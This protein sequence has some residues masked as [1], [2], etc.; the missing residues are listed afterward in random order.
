MTK[1]DLVRKI[2]V[3][4]GIVRR[5]VAIVVD[6]LLEAIKDTMKKGNH[7]EIRLFGT[8]NLRIR[9]ARIGRN[10]KTNDKVN[11]P[12]RV[13]PTFKFSKEFKTDIL[14]NVKP[15]QISEK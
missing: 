7:I 11:V 13:V 6:S 1:A 12:K 10:P 8:F 15:D 9:K 3:E 4:T 2:T 5:D 14:K